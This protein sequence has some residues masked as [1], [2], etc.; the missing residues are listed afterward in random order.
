VDRGGDVVTLQTI[1]ERIAAAIREQ[2]D[3]AR[4]LAGADR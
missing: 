4:A 3:R 2:L 1:S